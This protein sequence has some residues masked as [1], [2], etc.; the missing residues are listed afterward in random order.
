MGSVEQDPAGRQVPRDR[1]SPLFT[2]RS[3]IAESDLSMAEKCVAY[4]LSLH[5]NERGGSC[6]PSLDTLHRESGASL[7]TVKR[8]LGTLEEKGFLARERSPGGKTST[9]YTALI[10]SWLT[11]SQPRVSRRLAQGEP[12]ERHGER[13]S[14]TASGSVPSGTSSHLGSASPTKERK[15]DEIFEALVEVCG[16]DLQSLTS[17]ARGRVNRACSELRHLPQVPDAD[18]IKAFAVFWL[19]HYPGADLTPQAVTGNWAAWKGGK[20]FEQRRR[21]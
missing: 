11:V 17:S 4:T 3:A 14:S 19:M 20:L 8:A 5:M 21:R 16:W 15:K 18:E 6:F 10:P 2:W 13:S 9:R 1:L 12:R 7:A